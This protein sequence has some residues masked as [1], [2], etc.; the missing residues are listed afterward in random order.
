MRILIDECIDERFRNS[1][2]GHD[3]Q[4]ARHT[5][6]A[7]LKNGDLLKAAEAGKFDVFLTVDPNYFFFP[8]LDQRSLATGFGS[9]AHK[10][11]RSTTYGL[12]R[13]CKKQKTYGKVK[14]FRCNTYRKHGG[15]GTVHRHEV[16]GIYPLVEEC[17]PCLK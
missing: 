1:L 13:K 14:P 5:G 7:G 10:A 15:G 16:A 8:Q 12:P 9:L 2:A 3:C 11:F 6:L 4:T 17:Q